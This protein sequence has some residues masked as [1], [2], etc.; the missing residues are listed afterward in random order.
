MS[1][2]TAAARALLVAAACAAL[3]TA[4]TASPR[5][6]A[7]KPAH[8]VDPPV[9]GSLAAGEPIS[10]DLKDAD[11]KDVLRTFAKLARVNIAIDPEVKGSV[12]VRLHDVP[13]DQALDVILQVNG[14]G[15]VLEGNVLR[16]GEPRKLLPANPS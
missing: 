14:L 2:M 12:T 9:A 6:R 7:D 15:C 4:A 10:L 11:L 8:P 13:W 1:R 5:R 16:V 3:T